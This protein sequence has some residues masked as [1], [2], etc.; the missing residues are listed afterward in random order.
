MELEASDT[1][2]AELW[3]SDVTVEMD[4]KPLPQI[5]L[6]FQEPVQQPDTSSSSD[7]EKEKDESVQADWPLP[8]NQ[9]RRARKPVNG[10]YF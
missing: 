8:P 5:Q 1:A 2:V 4:R 10:N 6:P 3:G 7:Q 9:I